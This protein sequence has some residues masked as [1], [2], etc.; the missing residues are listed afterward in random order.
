MEDFISTLVALA[1][2]WSF[3]Q[4]A[5]GKKPQGGR[6]P[7]APRRQGEGPGVPGSEDRS[8]SVEGG[9]SP[10]AA[11]RVG[12]PVLRDEEPE[13]LTA[14]DLIPD[15]LWEILT[16][17]RRSRPPAQRPA[18]RSEPEP[19]PELEP[20][21]LEP[22]GPWSFNTDEP[23]WEDDRYAPAGVMEGPAGAAAPGGPGL[24]GVE[25]PSWLVQ[26]PGSPI[27]EPV[28]ELTAPAAEPRSVGRRRASG[29]ARLGNLRRAVVLREILGPPK[30]LE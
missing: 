30:A 23:F 14:A 13:E 26:E 5:L 4:A 1:I 21:T 11:G 28:V 17:E 22:T 18:P 24:R 8:P 7:R 27:Y 12:G 10:V 19:E 15:D 25:E 20:A 2:L 3:L 6:S 16:G 29:V 9:S